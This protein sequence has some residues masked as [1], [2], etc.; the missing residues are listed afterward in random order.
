MLI[1]MLKAGKVTISL[2]KHFSL[3]MNSWKLWKEAPCTAVVRVENDD[4]NNN[5]L[6]IYAD[7]NTFKLAFTEQNKGKFL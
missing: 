6:R 7:I 1:S 5:C 3:S 4:D 2:L